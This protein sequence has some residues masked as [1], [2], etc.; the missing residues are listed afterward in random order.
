MYVFIGLVVATSS[1]F[2][3]EQF[4]K[5][6]GFVNDYTE[7]LS[8]ETK[9]TLEGLLTRFQASGKGEVAVVIISTLRGDTIEDYSLQLARE[10]EI[11]VKGKDNGVLLFIAKDDRELRIEV[12]YGFEG[13][14]TDAKSS[15]IIRDIITPRF[16]EGNYDAGVVNGVKEI[17]GVVEPTF[18]GGAQTLDYSVEPTHSPIN[19]ELVALAL[20]FTGSIF[21]AI[22]S[23][24]GRSKSWW[25][26]GIFGIIIGAII[27]TV[28]GF[29]YV[30]IIAMAI[31][32]PLGFLFDYV[33]SMGYANSIANGTRPPWWTGGGSSG[34]RS[35]GFGGFGGGSFG[36]GGA[37]G[38][39]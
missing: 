32:V 24:L 10:W 12:G 11:G 18:E 14:L 9:T 20:Y 30:G 34:G 36:G 19:I 35:G 29:L 5:P 2:A 31:L 39:W 16:K 37:S 13:V 23:I 33:V 4:G 6:T 8:A 26:G 1:A 15:R 28:F 27:S 38:R 22:A 17:L 3:Y 25:L 21:V 7:T